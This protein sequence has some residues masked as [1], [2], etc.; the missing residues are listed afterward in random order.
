MDLSNSDC[1][2]S[3]IDAFL[4]QEA[5]GSQALSFWSC[6]PRLTASE[7]AVLSAL[8]LQTEGVGAVAAMLGREVGETQRFLDALVAVGIL[9]VSDHLYRATA[10][11]AAYC[12]MV[13]ARTTPGID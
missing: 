7:V 3:A 2:F 6:R 8:A 12:Q 4:R 5:R 1:L 11:T 13:T 10:A 9:D